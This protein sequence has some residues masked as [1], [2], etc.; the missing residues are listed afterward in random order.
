MVSN[1]VIVTERNISTHD[2][3]VFLPDSEQAKKLISCQS[4]TT[5][6]RGA[7]KQLKQKQNITMVKILSLGVVRCGN[8]IPDPIICTLGTELSSFGFFQK[9]VRQHK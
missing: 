3:R 7:T 8:D 9:P 2:L 6:K 4:T 1:S 5:T